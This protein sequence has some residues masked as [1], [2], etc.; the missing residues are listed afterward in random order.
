[1]FVGIVFTEVAAP[2][3]ATLE[4]R[5][6]YS[7]RHGQQVSKVQSGVP[8]GVIFTT[9]AHANPRRARVE[10]GELLERQ[11]HFV[12]VAND[13]DQA[14]HRRLQLLLDHIRILATRAAL[15][16]LE[17]RSFRAGYRP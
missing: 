5:S 8:A 12:F 2:A 17:R 6:G 9:A 1:M 7:F 15:E 4:R 14:L 11:S 13:A 3:L 10:I 16:G